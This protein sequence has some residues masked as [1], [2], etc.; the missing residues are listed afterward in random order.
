MFDNHPICSTDRYSNV[1]IF[2]TI[3]AT[4]S[5]RYNSTIYIYNF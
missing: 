4:K 5:F 3:G 1:Y 2:P